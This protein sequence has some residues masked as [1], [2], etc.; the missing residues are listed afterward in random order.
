MSGTDFFLERWVTADEL[1]GA[2]VDALGVSDVEVVRDLA[3]LVGGQPAYAA[4]YEAGGE[5][6]AHVS[7]D[8]DGDRETVRAVARALG[9]RALADDG[10]ANPYTWILVHP[11]GREETVS[12]EPREDEDINLYKP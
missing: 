5:F 2:L 7:V 11:D 1:R 3:D 10:S 6:A 4:L 12:I 8:P 9:T